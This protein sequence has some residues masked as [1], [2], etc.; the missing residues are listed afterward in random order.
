VSP[1]EEA[2]RVTRHAEIAG[3]GISGLGLACMLR[4]QGWSVRVHEQSTQVRDGGAALA[5]GQNGVNALRRM[6]ALEKALEGGRR[7]DYWNI[8]DASERILQE[9]H[10]TSE[11]YSIPRSSLLRSVYER[12]L[13]LGVEVVTESRMAGYRQGRLIAETGEEF[14]ADLV[15]GADGTWSVIRRS[16]AEQ[17]VPV[18]ELNLKV[19]GLRTNIP[20][21]PSDT[22][23]R[24]LEWLSGTRR[25][26][27]LPLN[28]DESY[29]YMFA[30]DS[31]VDGRRT[32]IDVDS[33]TRSY[34][35]L[36][37]VFERVP[38]DAVFREI[39]EI[40][41]GSWTLDNAALIGDAA[42]GMAPNLGQGA[43]T[44]LQAAVS[45]GDAVA[46]AADIPIALAQWQ[47]SERPHVDYVQKWSGRYSRWCSKTPPFATP[48]RSALFSAWGRSEK[49]QR[50]FSG[51]EARILQDVTVD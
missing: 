17:G 14:P 4:A 5:L 29:L 41:C 6:G 7:V 26:G 51:M 32:P 18:R 31:D 21:D 22:T 3:A 37:S 43:C 1:G 33:W 23:S 2:V 34:P 44:G 24:M 16:F 40:R 28:E 9:D 12:A 20:R 47:R 8:M 13:D 42:F 45:L 15:V 36:R 50:R 27:L 48:V 30:S 10:V 49:L 46:H 39:I 11:L 38:A 19:A 35:Y 25:V